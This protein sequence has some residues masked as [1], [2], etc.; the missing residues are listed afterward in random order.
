[1]KNT[2]CLAFDIEKAKIMPEGDP[3]WK[4]CRPLGIAC[5]ATLLNGTNEVDLWR[6]R[7]KSMAIKRMFGIGQLN[8][9]WTLPS[10]LSENPCCRTTLFSP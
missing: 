2:K 3:N 8:P 4:T 10:R 7:G 6:G 9:D 1:M 5:A